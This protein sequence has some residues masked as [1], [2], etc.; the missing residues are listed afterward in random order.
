MNSPIISRVDGE[1][2]YADH[3]STENLRRKCADHAVMR[4]DADR[5]VDVD[6]VLEHQTLTEAL[7]PRGQVD[8]IVASHVIEHLP[9]PVRWLR[10]LGGAL[11]P[12]G[13][14]FLVVPDK[15]F[16]FDFRRAPST[17]GDLVAHYLANPRIASPAQAFEH[18]ARTV[19]VNLN[20]KWAGRGR[21]PKDMFDGQLRNALN[22]AID[23]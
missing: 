7:G 16:T 17:T 11:K 1:I 3:L 13:I 5:I 18:V 14:L 19:E 20:A 21:K 8:Y 10:D 2:L 22:V 4:P 12:G 9:D 23:V 15:R 6:L